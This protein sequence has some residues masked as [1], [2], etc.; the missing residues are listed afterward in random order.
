MNAWTNFVTAGSKGFAWLL[1][2]SWQALLLLGAVWLGVKIWRAKSPALRHHVWLAALLVVALLPMLAAVVEKLPLPQ[3]QNRALNFVATIPQPAIVI[4]LPSS[5]HTQPSVEAVA[6]TQPKPNKQPTLWAAIFWLWSAGASFFLVRLWR[7]QMGIWR[8][9]AEAQPVSA[10]ELDCEDSPIEFAFS[11]KINS[12]VLLGVWR[13]MILL[14]A[15]IADW[16]NGDERQAMIGHELAHLARRDHLTN[17]FQNLIGVVFFFHP[18][19]RI[20]CRQLQI[21]REM[22][23]DDQVINSGAKSDLYAEIILKTAERSISK[24]GLPASS[25][26]GA[27]QLAFFS[28]RKTLERRIEMILNPDHIRVVTRQWRYLILPVAMI[29]VAAWLLLPARLTQSGIA[30]QRQ[31]ADDINELAIKYMADSKNFDDL[32][33]TALTHPDPTMR[34]KA[35][36]RLYVME[37]DGSTAAMVKLYNRSSEPEVKTMLIDALARISQIEPLTKIA[38]SDPSAEYRQQALERIKWLKETSESKDIKDWNVPELQNQLNSLQGQPLASP[39][40]VLTKKE[41]LSS[42]SGNDEQVLIEMVQK[43]IDGI[44]ERK[45]GDAN[46]G[47]A[48]FINTAAMPMTGMLAEFKGHDFEIKKVIADDFEVL[49]HEG[50]ATVTFNATIRA[51]NLAT[52]K[53]AREFPIRYAVRMKNETGQ[54]HVDRSSDWLEQ[55]QKFKPA[56]PPPPPVPQKGTMPPPPPPP[57]PPFA[58]Q[59]PNKDYN[60]QVIGKEPGGEYAFQ[61]NGKEQLSQQVRI[62]VS[63]GD[64]EGNSGLRFRMRNFDL[65]TANVAQVKG[66]YYLLDRFEIDRKGQVLYGTGTLKISNNGRSV[67]Y[68]LSSDGGIYLSPQRTGQRIDFQSLLWQVSQ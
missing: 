63:A 50:W 15:D 37:G 8:L 60:F 14:P 55:T 10:A 68:S 64:F 27:H 9:R 12:P 54:W 23:C 24:I 51:H 35:V 13:P 7:Q 43:V 18:L 45:Y 65:R 62:N 19:V 34:Q 58:A 40:P 53:D 30:R 41:L 22:A 39:P 38:L 33:E 52:G 32:V 28:N 20:A 17:M 25:P 47:V 61:I 56:P 21:E 42:L 11:S 4:E 66:S 5:T 1:A 67:E 48:D 3:P 31:S 44:P 57:P 29:A 6:T 16:T 59:L 46:L 36:L 2:W 49:L 26:G